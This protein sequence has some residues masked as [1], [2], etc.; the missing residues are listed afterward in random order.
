FDGEHR[1]IIMH[2]TPLRDT[3]DKIIGAIEVN[4]DITD[5]KNTERN[6]KTSLTQWQAV[7]D[8]DQFAVIQLDENLQIKKVSEK[9][10]KS[11]KP[12]AKKW[13]L[14]DLLDSAITENIL[15]RLANVPSQKFI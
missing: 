2:A 6:L 8:Q 7:F 3:D 4:Q 12:K 11:L 15:K 13:Q 10:K 1:T 5:L 14:T 9:L